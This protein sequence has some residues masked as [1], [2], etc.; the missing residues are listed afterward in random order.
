VRGN[1]EAL[2]KYVTDPAGWGLPAGH[3]VTR[4]QPGDPSTLLDD[5][6]DAAEAAT[7]TL[8]VYYAGHGATGW[9]GDDTDLRLA[10]RAARTGRP[11]HWLRYSDVREAV[12]HTRARSRI[13]ILDCCYAGRAIDGG[14][15]AGEQRPGE[16]LFELAETDGAVVLTAAS[17][18]EQAMCP[19]GWAYSAFTGELVGLLRD[20]VTGPVPHHPEGRLGEELRLLDM[21]TVHA[22]LRERL[23]GRDVAG[24][25][26][27]EPQLGT[28]NQGGTIALGPNPAYTGPRPAPT[29]PDPAQAAVPSAA[30]SAPS[31]LPAPD[32][33]FLGG[34][35]EL[36][37][38]ERSADLVLTDGRPAT[39]L[40]HGM[41]GVGKTALVE[42]AAH[43]LKDRFPDG[44]IEINLN[45][46]ETET[47]PDADTGTRTGT[48]T[49]TGTGT[50]TGTRTVGG[51]RRA[52]PLSAEAALERLLSIVRHPR[53]PAD[54]AGRAD[55]W[56]AW[57]SGRR[58]LLV[59]DNAADAR[60]IAP[61]LPGADA[62]CLV[63]VSSRSQDFPVPSTH[64][65]ALDAMDE[66]TAVA[67][68]RAAGNLPAEDD[69]V[70]GT[71]PR[72]QAELAELARRCCHLPV[73]LRT[74]GAGL[75][76]SSAG[77]L[78]AAMD[79]D[80][81]AEF[82]HAE[83]AVRGAFQIS[84]DALPADLREV[85]HHCAW[86]PGR[87]YSAETVAAMADIPTPRAELRLGRLLD[88]H[89]LQRIQ[90]AITFHDLYL[91]RARATAEAAAPP[92]RQQAARG[93]LYRYLLAH[94][95]AAHLALYGEHPERADAAGD[96]RFE[97]PWPALCWLRE[98]SAALEASASAALSDAWPGAGR[99]ATECGRWL[100]YDHRPG[101]AA[102]LARQALDL[103][104]H[105][106]D[107]QERA[108]ALLDL[109]H[110]ERISNRP[111]S[112]LS[113][114]RQAHDLAADTGDR[115]TVAR[116]LW[117]FADTYRVLNEHGTA[118]TLYRK[119]LA[120]AEETGDRLCE[121]S[122][123][124]GLADTHSTRGDVD[125][126]AG[127]Y[128]RALH[129]AEETDNCLGR[130]DALVGLGEIA[131]AQG[132]AAAAG[133]HF[134]DAHGLALDSG[135]RQAQTHALSG[136]AGSHRLQ[137]DYGTA[138][139]LYRQ[140]RDHAEE[141]G[142]LHARAG[143]LQG[144]G[145]CHNALAEPDKAAACFREAMTLF[146]SLGISYWAE[147]CREELG[148]G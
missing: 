39:W 110:S 71:D 58:V 78:V 42:Q 30:P 131:L 121:T 123:L 11:G 89:L 31:N 108:D 75:R 16:R 53:I 34:D 132:R 23:T 25:P 113:Y 55:E 135:N 104:D 100:R 32:P 27:P 111:T 106:H 116:A 28:R 51:V 84:Y 2:S 81:L 43:R 79:D 60:T 141:T 50:G 77:S 35:A 72:A 15:S 29:P 136:L 101:T 85:L 49:D 92:Q 4:P 119:S 126:A 44:R 45:G 98:H 26:L 99:L 139:A 125:L 69:T 122:A 68:L 117:S 62:H 124:D 38:L 37:R 8:L 138:V 114:Y 40:V 65:I 107:V 47:H 90:G 143:A 127:L 128:A 59:L 6:Y 120:L 7:D 21:T 5:L 96:T 147:Q 86:H 13:V 129:L 17:G 137:D 146:E 19:P 144:L 12:R 73:V 20:G 66:D 133:E 41:G 102:R 93:R 148:E 24:H 140:A 36:A 134:R 115:R 10:M 1:I 103:A 14:M 97:G 109:G 91:P 56:R 61:L 70:P 57:L 87:S 48:R 83:A 112:A 63:L 54:L 80:S 145:H 105:T 95:S 74:I 130:A 82:P 18:V 88:V 142:D 22:L 52:E 64:R 33:M 9:G 94:V 76:H 46:F 67:L 118:I 3:A